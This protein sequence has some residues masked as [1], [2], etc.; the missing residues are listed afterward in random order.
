LISYH[1]TFKEL[2]KLKL[3]YGFLIGVHQSLCDES[4]DY[5]KLVFDNFFEERQVN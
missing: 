3:N 4:M 2:D 5:V 1:L